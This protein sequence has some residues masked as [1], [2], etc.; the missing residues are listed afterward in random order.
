MNMPRIVLVSATALAFSFG[1]GAAFAQSP[2]HVQPITSNQV[3][4]DAAKPTATAPAQK[5]D[6]SKA[7]SAAADKQSLHG[8]ARKKFRADCKMHGG[9]AT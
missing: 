4:P 3:P 1:A 7:C 9:P 6:V 8:K 2:A 5:T